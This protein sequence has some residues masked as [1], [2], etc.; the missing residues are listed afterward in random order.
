M[1]KIKELKAKARDVI[2]KNY[3]TVI[4]VCFLLA[5]VTGEF[6]TSIIGWIQSEDSLDFDY[7]V[8]Q[9]QITSD[10]SVDKSKVE[11]IKE[12]V[13]KLTSNSTMGNLTDVENKLLE[14]IKA[15]VNSASK[16]Q[17]YILKIFDAIT[18]FN[19][20]EPYTGITL[21]ITA[22]IALLYTIIIGDPLI[23]AGRKYF[24][25]ARKG[26]N[27]KTTGIASKIFEKNNW[28]NVAVIMFLKNLYNFLWYITIVGGVVKMYEYRMIPYI[29]AEEPEINKK[30][31]FRKSKE[32]MKNNK[33]RA[34]LL[35]LS[36]IGWHVVSLLTF[37]IVNILYGNSYM[38]ATSTEL[39]VVLKQNLEEK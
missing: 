21:S 5:L 24:L 26:S 32:M 28:I 7:I 9:E 30:E 29:L 20:N 1:W 3:W 12:K 11:S 22:L 17:K 18:S 6:G 10:E 19:I 25:E 4:L 31:A 13:S 27:I 38:A 36:F 33:W 8:E 35:D 16:S 37:G 15:N 2:K 14:M 34:F 39:Y 23:V